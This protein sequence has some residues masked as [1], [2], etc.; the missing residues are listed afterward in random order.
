MRKKTVTKGRGRSLEEDRARE[1]AEGTTELT[2][3]GK[4]VDKREKASQN[5]PPRA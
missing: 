5:K 3:T 1:G 4:K 2:H